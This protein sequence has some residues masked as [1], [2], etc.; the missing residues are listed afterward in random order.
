[1]GIGMVDTFEV[2]PVNNTPG[3]NYRDFALVKNHE[4]DDVS[5]FASES[6]ID[7]SSYQEDI[8][9]LN[10]KLAA[11]A[12]EQGIFSKTWNGVKELI[13]KG[14]SE[15]K[16]EEAIEQYKNG[17]ISYEQAASVIDNYS[18]KQKSSLD[19]FANI[20]T[21]VTS[22]LAGTAA[23]AAIIASGGTA[24]PIVVAA[25]A[26]AGAGAVTK[27][28]FKLTDRAT[29]DVKD[30]AL[31]G[32]QIARDAISG[33]ITGAISGATM[34]NGTT[35]GSV[36]QSVKTS[37][38]KASKTGLIT[39]SVSGSSN[40]ILDC[41]FDEDKEFNTSELL[42]NTATGAI[43]SGTVGG[44]IG[45]SNGFLRG[46]NLISNGGMVKAATDNAGNKIVEDT[47]KYAVQNASKEA[48]VANSVC[49]TEYKIMTQG[50][51]DASSNL[52]A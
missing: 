8:D 11:V 4:D 22:I 17:E 12:A 34:G 52:A 41:A 23:A 6:Q 43:V 31:N 35:A 40:Y 10:D 24:A 19:L 44:I 20:T 7:N 36:A 14:T 48:I 1:M 37:A 27:S 49:S 42:V 29:N 26:G 51:K 2:N 45:S 5:I 13:N 3:L 21:G 32:K 47:G 50:L 9:G 15:E 30:D 18:E 38:L 39:G 16:C 28:G 46:N 25:L 33:A